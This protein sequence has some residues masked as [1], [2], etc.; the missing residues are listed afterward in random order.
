MTPRR[1]DEQTP[2]KAFGKQV[3]RFRDLTG[4]SQEQLGQKTHVTG[5]F[6]GAIERGESRCQRELAVTMDDVLDTRGTLPS[7]WDDFVMH[8]AFPV[9]FNWPKVESKAN[10]LM[11]YQPLAVWGLLQNE[12][13][14]EIVLGGDRAAVEARMGRQALLTREDPPPPAVTVVLSELALL[15]Q[16]GDARIMREQLERLITAAETGTTIQIVPNGAR[17]PGNTGGFV[18]AT[19]ENR[20]EVAYVDTGARGMTLSSNE[21]ILTLNTSFNAIRAQALPVGMSIDLIRRTV[22]QRWT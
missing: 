1:S 19:L 9:W 16:I 5:S 7:L 20:A 6:I 15:N 11:T 10:T 17:H 18:L 12:E 13:Y 14:A 22:E 3:K 4:L 21:D 2:L 8:A